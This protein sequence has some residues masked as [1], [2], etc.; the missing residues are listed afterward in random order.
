MAVSAKKNLRVCKVIDSLGDYYDIIVAVDDLDEVDGIIADWATD[1][2]LTV[3]LPSGLVYCKDISEVITTLDIDEYA[4]VQSTSTSYNT[5]VTNNLVLPK[6][7]GKGIMVDTTTPTFG[8]KVRE[9]IEITNLAGDDAPALTVFRGG[10]VREL[11]YDVND[12]ADIRIPIPHD[13]AP[14]TDI[15]LFVRFAHNGATISGNFVCTNL[16][17]Y[18]KGHDQAVFPAEK[19][20]LI[21]TSTPD[22]TTIPQYQHFTELVQLSATS[23]SGS[24]I[25][26]DDLEIDGVIDLNMEVTT[27]PTISGGTSTRVFIMGMGIYYQSTQLATKSRVPDFYV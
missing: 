26:S 10:N 18:A 13:Y 25:D 23:P 22:I 2:S 7:S 9:G 5:T 21:S 3:T 27:L 24:Q 20:I 8:W 11:A 4:Y 14:G 16:Y 1:N 19:T 17:T 12:K 6:T 15:Y